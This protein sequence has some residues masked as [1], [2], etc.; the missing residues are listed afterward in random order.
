L[1]DVSVRGWLLLFRPE[2]L[3]TIRWAGQPLKRTEETPD[4]QLRLSPRESFAVWQEEVRGYSL[5]WRETDIQAA[6][7]LGDDLAVTAS[8]HEI[9]RLNDSLLRQREALAE[10]ND[11]LRELAHTDTLTG[12]FN[13]YRIEHLVQMAL[14]NAQRYD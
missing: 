11:H 4:G 10:A 8:A 9:S 12:T 13:R 6:R 14:A 3:Q 5:A 2:Q 7:D 1:F